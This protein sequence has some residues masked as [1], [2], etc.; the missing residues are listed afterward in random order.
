MIANKIL[1]YMISEANR[2]DSAGNFTKAD[3]LDRHLQNLT[4][5][6]ASTS[7]VAYHYP[8]RGADVNSVMK[9]GILAPSM[10]AERPIFK[11]VVDNYKKRIK[12]VYDGD[13]TNEVVLDY[14]DYARASIDDK[15]YIGRNMVF[16]CISPV[17]KGVSKEHDK[18]ASETP[19]LIDLVALDKTKK[20]TF[21]VIELPF[22]S[23]GDS[24][25]KVTISDLK[26]LSRIDMMQFY[27]KKKSDGFLFG[28][29]P[30]L[31]IHIEGGVIEKKFLRLESEN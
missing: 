5:N 16:A 14:L 15:M 9:D 22:G 11:S 27:D 2:L 13:I 28:R 25:A 7:L 1:E 24:T 12:E 8:L 18:V 23:D 10:L 6:A 3:A 21:Y 31:A 19:I 26:W 17:L 30:H 29:V 4:K 20:A